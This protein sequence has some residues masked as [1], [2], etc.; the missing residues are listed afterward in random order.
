[1]I[2]ALRVKI[3]TYILAFTFCNFRANEI[4][5]PDNGG[6]ISNCYIT[7]AVLDFYLSNEDIYCV[8]NL[9]IS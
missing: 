7:E 4:I 8:C 6:T 9:C 3:Y 5:T 2:G 1:M